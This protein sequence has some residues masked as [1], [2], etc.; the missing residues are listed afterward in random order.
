MFFG[1]LLAS[2]LG[3]SEAA[4]DSALVLPLLATQIL[5]I[6]LVTDGAPALVLGLDPPDPDTMARPPRPP[7]E[8]VLTRRMWRGIFFVG[9]IFAIGTLLVLDASLPGGL[10]AGEG[11][12]SYG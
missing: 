1:V 10:I 2:W 9:S 8:G 7:H 5:W 4:G 11:D 3:L 6:N 12:L